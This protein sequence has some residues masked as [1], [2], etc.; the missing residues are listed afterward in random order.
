MDVLLVDQQDKAAM[1]SVAQDIPTSF[2]FARMIVVW[3]NANALQK[4][5][6]I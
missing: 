2:Q 3:E 5:R 1:I 6:K 4:R